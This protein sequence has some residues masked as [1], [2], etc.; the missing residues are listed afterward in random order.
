MQRL[1][2][3]RRSLLPLLLLG[4]SRADRAARA[5][6]NSLHAWAG[7]R[8]R[9]P[10]AAPHPPASGATPPATQRP[11]RNM[12]LQNVLITAEPSREAVFS[13]CDMRT[14]RRLA[15][16]DKFFRG[17]AGA[18]AARPGRGVTSADVTACI[19]V[20]VLYYA[21]GWRW[22]RT[23]G[24]RSNHWEPPA[25]GRKH[26]VPLAPA[27][28]HLPQEVPLRLIDTEL[29][30]VCCE[31]DILMKWVPSSNERVLIRMDSGCP[32]HVLC[33]KEAKDARH[34]TS[35]H[36]ING[37]N[38]T[39][40]RGIY[41]ACDGTSYGR[42]AITFEGEGTTLH[43]EHCDLEGGV[44]IG[45]EEEGEEEEEEEEEGVSTPRAFFR[46]C[47]LHGAV[48]D[49]LVV[50]NAHA[51]LRHCEMTG[52]EGL[53][54][55]G[56][57]LRMIDSTISGARG[58]PNLEADHLFALFPEGDV[59]STISGATLIAQNCTFA[60]AGAGVVGVDEPGAR[61]ETEG[62]TWRNVTNHTE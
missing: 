32:V 43:M 11:C 6:E 58:G 34:S 15:A 14:L 3:V 35:G 21:C 19:H 5:A 13:H 33:R 12:L 60:D 55:P 47:K 40:L 37:A 4:R 48:F 23:E 61:V 20:H 49:F 50:Q 26:I 41:V 45:A 2:G 52:F 53:V 17:T 44:Y 28:Y 18:A 9:C 27:E 24:W 36:T 54:G 22:D 30:N 57:E 46:R 38:A 62:S 7:A 31:K 51:E 59:G 25:A 56:G 16:T 39:L 29:S 8:A 1:L 42:N 10:S